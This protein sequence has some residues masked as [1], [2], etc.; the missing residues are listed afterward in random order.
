MA[1]WE[2]AQ[3]S[4]ADQ[5]EAAVEAEMDRDPAE[6]VRDPELDSVCASDRIAIGPS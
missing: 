5:A 1:V 2:E 6:P 3:A 4:A